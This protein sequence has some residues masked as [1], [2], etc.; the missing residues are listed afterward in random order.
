MPTEVH[1]VKAMVFFSSHVWMWELGHKEGWAPKNWCLWTVVEDSWESL[2]LQGDQTEDET[3]GWHYWLNG[4]EFEQ[5]LGDCE[6]QGILACCSPRGCKESD[7]TEWLKNNDDLLGANST[8][9]GHGFQGLQTLSNR[10]SIMALTQ[11]D[12]LAQR[13]EPTLAAGKPPGLQSAPLIKHSL[14]TISVFTPGK[15]GD[16]SCPHNLP[17]WEARGQCCKGCD[18]WLNSSASPCGGSHSLSYTHTHTH[19]HT[20]TPPPKDPCSFLT[21]GSH[22]TTQDPWLPWNHKNQCP[23]PTSPLLFSLST[24]E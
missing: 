9:S 17:V 15:W 5:I 3:V 14:S 8:G 11:P 23:K 18:M 16:S 19:T 1:L 24:S 7:M 12:W 6:G 21:L 22:R 13:A 10:L 4:H 20:H 2:G